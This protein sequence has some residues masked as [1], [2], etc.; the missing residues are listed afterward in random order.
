MNNQPAFPTLHNGSTLTGQNG[1]TMR[2]YF[3]ARLMVY[4]LAKEQQPHQDYNYYNAAFR[5]YRMAD[6]MLKERDKQ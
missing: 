3:A 4:E 5:A 2:D 6:A 1:L